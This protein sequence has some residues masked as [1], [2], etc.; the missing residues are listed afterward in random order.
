MASAAAGWRGVAAFLI[1][2]ALRAAR[3]RRAG[4][5]LSE[6]DV[7]DLAALLVIGL[8]ASRTLAGA[9]EDASLQLGDATRGEV[10]D[11]LRR[12]RI[13]G[14]AAALAETDGPLAPLASQLARAQISGAPMVDAV[15]AFLQTRRGVVRS[16]LLES[17]RTLPVRLIVPVTLLLLPGFVLLLMGP[18]IVEQVGQLAGSGIP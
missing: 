3:L 16:T 9:L 7:D 18:F 4:P 11:L 1:W 13:R 2:S 14:L 12:A 5:P 8:S 6:S 15:A 10:V 17:A